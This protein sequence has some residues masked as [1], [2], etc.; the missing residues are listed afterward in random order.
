M[1]CNVAP[2]QLSPWRF[3]SILVSKFPMVDAQPKACMSA[4]NN[5]YCMRLL[6]LKLPTLRWAEAQ[7]HACNAWLSLLHAECIGR[8]E[9]DPAACARYVMGA[10]SVDQLACQPRVPA[11]W[12]PFL[13][14]HHSSQFETISTH[15]IY[16]PP[17]LAGIPG[18]KPALST[19][20]TLAPPT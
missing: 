19:V 6:P 3:V 16:T 20:A 10:E 12:Q 14:F 7:H 18:C 13:A 4:W 1:A 2:V 15:M 9:D 8:A 5:Q 11:L 17:C